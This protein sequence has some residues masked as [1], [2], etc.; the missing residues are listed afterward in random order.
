[1]AL[2]WIVTHE[3]RSDAAIHEAADSLDCRASLMGNDLR[4]CHHASGE[5]QS[6]SPNRKRRERGAQQVYT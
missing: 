6:A 1:M 4:Q 3:E 5:G 2:G